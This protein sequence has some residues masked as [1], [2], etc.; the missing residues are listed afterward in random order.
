MIHRAV[1]LHQT[2]PTIA[3]QIGH[4]LEV[5]SHNTP[6]Y[7]QFTCPGYGKSPGQA[8]PLTVKMSQL[9]HLP[10]QKRGPQTQTKYHARKELWAG[11]MP[12]LN[13]SP[14]IFY[15]S[16]NDERCQCR[17]VGLVYTGVLRVTEQELDNEDVSYPI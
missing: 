2:R 4:F 6:H 10:V 17:N 3:R 16:D 12:I 15:Q 11:P 14:P 7:R 13:F 5:R 9:Q 8:N 1:I